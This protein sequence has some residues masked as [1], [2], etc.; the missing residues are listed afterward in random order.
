MA[1]QV[2]SVD[3]FLEAIG[4]QT[5]ALFRKDP[6]T[7]ALAAL[8]VSVVGVLSLCIL[9]G[10]L[11]VGYLRLVQ[12]ASRGEQ[13]SYNEVFSGFSQ[14]LPAL[15]LGLLIGAGVTVGSVLCFFPG[16][17]FAVF[18]C[19]AYPAL[20]Y[21]G[22]GPV[23]AIARSFELVRGNV[24]NV[25]FTLLGLA[26]IQ[27]LGGAVLFGVIITAPLSMIALALTYER[28]SHSGSLTADDAAQ[29]YA[30]GFRTP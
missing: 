21:S 1:G 29:G 2:E 4:K 25:V 5:W 16:I 8:L 17:A 26:A 14:F 22:L 9:L 3:S 18:S 19:L 10:P 28:L 13:V 23:E 12:R 20:A 30:S 24:I 7:H 11:L 6:V 27:S 15:L